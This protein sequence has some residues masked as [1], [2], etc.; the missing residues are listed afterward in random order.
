MIINDSIDEVHEKEEEDDK[1]PLQKKK[2]YI[3]SLKNAKI[4]EKLDKIK[5][6][7]KIKYVINLINFKKCQIHQM[8]KC[9]LNMY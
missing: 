8:I 6:L 2:Q 7:I 5:K 1:P 9:L 4:K 3:N